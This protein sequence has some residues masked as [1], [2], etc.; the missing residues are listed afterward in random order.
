MICSTSND[1]SFSDYQVIG[2]VY[3]YADIGIISLQKM[4]EA[5]YKVNMRHS[6][7]YDI[8]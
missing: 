2:V 6:V 5:G 8:Y 7:N 4:L 3:G 1:L